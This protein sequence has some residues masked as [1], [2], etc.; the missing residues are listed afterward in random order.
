M[1]GKRET[2]WLTYFHCL[3]KESN[4]E[5]TA[6]FPACRQA[7]MRVFPRS[8]LAR[9]KLAKGTKLPRKL[10]EIRSAAGTIHTVLQEKK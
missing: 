4:K 9:P 8:T 10:L 6:D 1:L 3:C 2:C 7:G 5:S